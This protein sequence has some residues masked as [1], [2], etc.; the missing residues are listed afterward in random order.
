VPEWDFKGSFRVLMV[1]T[2]QSFGKTAITKPSAST[3]RRMF[4]QS[5]SLQQN[6]N[7]EKRFDGERIEEAFQASIC[8]GAG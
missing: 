5:L 7:G 4:V 1:V 3:W 6:A 2:L 8:Q